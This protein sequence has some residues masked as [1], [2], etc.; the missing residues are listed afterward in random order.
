[1]SNQSQS[2]WLSKGDAALQLHKYEGRWD[3]QLYV[4]WTTTTWNLKTQS[5]FKG[6]TRFSV[7]AHTKACYTQKMKTAHKVIT[8]YK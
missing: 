7:E 8:K 4:T 2:Y 1:M 6:T 3:R 5:I